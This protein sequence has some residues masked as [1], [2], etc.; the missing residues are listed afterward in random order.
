MEAVTVVDEYLQNIFN[1]SVNRTLNNIFSSIESI[2]ELPF[3]T[4][5]YDFDKLYLYIMDIMASDENL[6][7]DDINTDIKNYIKISIEIF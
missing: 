2:N 6:D 1:E 3:V 7:Q 4:K 5:D